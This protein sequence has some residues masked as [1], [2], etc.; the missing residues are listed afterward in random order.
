MAHDTF[1]GS[2]SYADMADAH[3]LDACVQYTDHKP[4]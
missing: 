3:T 2:R 4:I 1:Y